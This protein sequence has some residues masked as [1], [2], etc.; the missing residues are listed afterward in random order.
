MGELKSK[1][2]AL[3]ARQGV[4]GP[5]LRRTALELGMTGKKSPDEGASGGR[6]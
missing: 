5:H 3:A 1:S 6:T 2:D 4:D